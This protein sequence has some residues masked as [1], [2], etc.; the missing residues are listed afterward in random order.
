MILRLA[1]ND[2]PEIAVPVFDR[3]L[4][5]SRGSAQIIP[6]SVGFILVEGNYLLLDKEPWAQLHA[7]F[8]LTVM[9]DVAQDELARRLRLRW[10]GLGLNAQEIEKKLEQN[11]LPNGRLVNQKSTPAKLVLRPAG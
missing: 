8:D 11:D 2:E 6:S 4:E 9:I 3:V 7:L 1:A 5:I 10:Q